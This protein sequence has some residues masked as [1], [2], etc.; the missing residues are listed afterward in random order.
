MHALT[1]DDYYRAALAPMTRQKSKKR[2]LLTVVGER[3]DNWGRV[4]G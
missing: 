4:V 1:D 3:Q 2:P